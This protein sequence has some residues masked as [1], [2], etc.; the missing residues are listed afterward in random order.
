M[1]RK[2]IRNLLLLSFILLLGACSQNESSSS[3]NG[4]TE[5]EKI[6]VL[7]TIAQIGEPLSVIGGDLLEVKSLMGPSVDP[8]LYQA[9]HGDIQTIEKAD[10]IFYNGLN[11]EAKKG[12]TARC[13]SFFPYLACCSAII[14]SKRS[15]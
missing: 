7:T 11:L 4:Q 1:F 3:S 12:E 9:T 5:D 6:T 10:L 13:F 15:F 2:V 8:H 14:S